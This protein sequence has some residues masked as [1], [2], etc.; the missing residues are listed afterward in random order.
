MVLA[1]PYVRREF[2]KTFPQNV[3]TEIDSFAVN[4]IAANVETLSD[5]LSIYAERLLPNGQ[6]Q[7]KIVYLDKLYYSDTV[8]I[9]FPIDRSNAVELIE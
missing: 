5:S 9:Y 3:T 1:R 4:I 6:T 7:T 8:M 2:R